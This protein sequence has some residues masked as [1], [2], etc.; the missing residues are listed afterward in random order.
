MLWLSGFAARWGMR[1]AREQR[2]WL[3]GAFAVVS[4]VLLA[5]SRQGVGPTGGDLCRDYVSA[6]NI[7]HGRDPYALGNACGALDHSPHPPLAMLL[8]LTVAWLPIGAAGF[9][10]S[11]LMLASLVG[12]LWIIWNDALTDL[13]LRWAALGLAVL[14][15]WPPLL[16]TWLEA[17]ISPL[18]LLLIVLAWRARRTGH[19]VAAGA[20]L[21][22]ATLIR[23]YPVLLFLYPLLR[24]EWRVVQGGIA[25][26]LG[27]TLVTLLWLSPA[28][29]VRYIGEAG[30]ASSDWVNAAHN[31]S[32]RG[33]VGQILFGSAT[34]HPVIQAPA[35]V[36]PMTVVGTLAFIG[37]LLWQGWQARTA[38]LG[39]AW[40][41]RAWLLAIPVMLAVSPLAWPHYFIIILLPW[42]VLVGQWWQHEWDAN[43][44]MLVA[45]VALLFLNAVGI[46]L[47]AKAPLPMPWP[48]ELL[49]FALPFYTLILSSITLVRTPIGQSAARHQPNVL[50]EH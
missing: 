33:V 50:S 11:L 34:V 8:M 3:L 30:A 17:Q 42:L 14:A 44:W 37:L 5:L 2:A 4:I 49:V 39:S 6:A 21:A 47:V 23:L 32:L 28:A 45:A 41:D 27:V 26:G 16:D 31:V 36:L 40:D 43:A 22:V 48:V 29:Y 12:A 9:V 35:L 46:G 18:I 7:W 10:W 24:R 19:P 20:W 15:I 38:P 25:G 1:T 13:P